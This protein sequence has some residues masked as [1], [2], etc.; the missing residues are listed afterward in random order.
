MKKTIVFAV[1]FIGAILFFK[2]TPEFSL[3]QVA[4][5]SCDRWGVRALSSQE[6][7]VVQA[8]LAQPFV[9]SGCGAQAYVFF[10]EDGHFVLKLF[11]KKRFEVPM[12]VR[13]L[14]PLPYKTKKIVSKRENLIKDFTSYQIAY[15]ELQEETGLLLVHLDN[16]PLP[17]AL[18]FIDAHKVNLNDYAFIL[19][20]RGELVCSALDRY[21]KQ[22]EIETAKQAL[23]SLVQLLKTRCDK[24]IA[25]RDPNFGKNYAFLEGVKAVEIDIGRFSHTPVQVPK[26]PQAFKEWLQNLSPELADHFLLLNGLLESSSQEDGCHKP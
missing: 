21:V 20:K 1:L 17:H 18:T 13:M 11:K 16:T 5:A 9:Y 15:N 14:P 8:A 24:G 4:R 19:Q 10:S 7:Q 23:T 3:S 25:D 26:I 6:E 22:G 2:P 12:W